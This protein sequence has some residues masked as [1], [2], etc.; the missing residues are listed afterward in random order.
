MDEMVPEL[1]WNKNVFW[2]QPFFSKKKLRD[3]SLHVILGD[4]GPSAA[5]RQFGYIAAGGLALI[6]KF[7][8]GAAGFGGSRR[9]LR[10]PLFRYPLSPH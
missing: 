8:I 1:I 10:S 6:P 5:Y 4:P 7:M 9:A 2:R 3:Y